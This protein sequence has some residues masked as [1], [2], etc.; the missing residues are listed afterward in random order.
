MKSVR[1]DVFS[2][3]LLVAM[4][5]P[6]SMGD[7]CLSCLESQGAEVSHACCATGHETKRAADPC[8]HE[9]SDLDNECLGACLAAHIDSAALS[10]K[11]VTTEPLVAAD[12]EVQRSSFCL[13]I[14]ESFPHPPNSHLTGLHVSISTTVLRI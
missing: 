12:Y 14:S 3:L 9:G 4:V 11:V 1:I 7:A 13:E 6:M 5:M 10:T 2:L 8:S